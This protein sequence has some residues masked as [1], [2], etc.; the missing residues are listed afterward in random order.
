MATTAIRLLRRTAALVLLLTLALA[1][2]TSPGWAASRVAAGQPLCLGDTIWDEASQQCVPLGDETASAEPEPIQPSTEPSVEPSVAPTVLP[3]VV[4]SEAPLASNSA[5]PSA[6]PPADTERDGSRRSFFQT[7][8]HDCPADRDW[9]TLA[10]AAP[11]YLICPDPP[12][13]AIP[14]VISV[15]GQPVANPI[16]STAASGASAYAPDI[17]PGDVTIQEEIPAGYGT[18][19]A[20]CRLVSI[21]GQVVREMQRYLVT[22]VGGITIDDVVD[23]EGIY[24]EW[25][26][27]P[28]DINP[29]VF[30]SSYQCPAG[31]DAAGVEPTD[32]RIACPAI[33]AGHEFS[34]AALDRFVEGRTEGAL[35]LI[36]GQLRVG[37]VIITGVQPA[38]YGAPYVF[39]AVTGP[40][41]QTLRAYDYQFPSGPD[42]IMYQLDTFETLRCDWFFIPGNGAAGNSVFTGC[43]DQGT[44][45]ASTEGAGIAVG[46][47]IV[48]RDDGGDNG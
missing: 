31:F 29:A 45:R 8:I 26:N 47:A 27:V 20:Y 3:D 19:L 48:C 28:L 13:T 42:S 32:L 11:Q 14:F 33:P 43:N 1:S 36:F 30:L 6:N 35:A 7:F 16:G 40:E 2:L 37:S 44:P 4:A 39:C 21:D 9:Y 23:G 15:D 5:S 18:P 12:Q 38:T 17:P 41:G 24:C 34:L 25:S 46:R 10:D 22:G